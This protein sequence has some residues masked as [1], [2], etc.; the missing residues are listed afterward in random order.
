MGNHDNDRV[1][2]IG[3]GVAGLTA[4]ATA[5]RAG[6]PVVLLEGHEAGGRART[7]QRSG[8]S[9]NQ[10][11]HAL[12]R[13]GPAW[14]TLRDLGLR[15]RGHRPP[16]RGMRGVRAGQVVPV[17]GRQVAAVVAKLTGARPSAW[18]GRSTREWVD[19]LGFGRE[20]VETAEMMVRV[21]TYV[22]DLDRLPADLALRQGRQGLVHGVSYLDGGWGTLVEGLAGAATRAGATLRRHTEARSITGGPADW[23]VVTAEG[24]TLHATA[25]VVAAGG[26]AA[27]RKLLPVDPHWGELGAPVTAACLDLGLRGPG[28]KV[29]FGLDVPWYLSRHCPP[30][31]LAPEGSALAHVLRYGARDARADR[32]ELVDLARMAGVRDE[33]IVEDRFL[34]HMVVTHVLPSPERGL[35]GRPPVVVPGPGGLFVAGDWVGDRGWLADAAVASGRSAGLLAAEFRATLQGDDPVRVA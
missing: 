27:A 19:S 29:V 22:A 35:A 26:P 23:H 10:G 8:F 28:P 33:H 24:E 18:A 30:G 15:L 1:V 9:F 12:Y 6:R 16:L 17:G 4:A 31:D 14:R 20:A 25:V 32:A 5:A 11:P 7:D 13:G 3:A 34:A 2:V 21:A